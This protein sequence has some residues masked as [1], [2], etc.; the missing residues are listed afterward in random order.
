MGYRGDG[1]AVG[2]AAA[3]HVV[4]PPATAACLSGVVA[5]PADP[6]HRRSGAAG[7]GFTRY[8][9]SRKSAITRQSP[10]R[11]MRQAWYLRNML[12]DQQLRQRGTVGLGEGQIGVVATDDHHRQASVL[13]AVAARVQPPSPDRLSARSVFDGPRAGRNQ[14]CGAAGDH[15]RTGIRWQRLG[16]FWPSSRRD[17]TVVWQIGCR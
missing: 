13:P 9:V 3:H 14:T 8:R 6:P 15:Q 7:P 12:A 1:Q 11:Q 5:G 2:A 17:K 16:R 10:T 4:H